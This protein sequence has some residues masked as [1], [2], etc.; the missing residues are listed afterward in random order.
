MTIIEELRSKESRDN[1]ALLDRAADRIAELEKEVDRLSQVVLY[2]NSVT[3]MKVC[4]AR[5]RVV[6]DIFDDIERLLFANRF[7]TLEGVYYH[8]ELKDHIAELK[9][10]YVEG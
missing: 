7:F 5:E 10:I 6:I 4:E 1:R 3:E 2:N 9:K 8:K